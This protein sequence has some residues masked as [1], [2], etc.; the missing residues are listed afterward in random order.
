MVKFVRSVSPAQGFAGLHSGHGH[1]TTHPAM[2][3]WCP[4]CHNQK[5]LQLEYTTMYW[6]ALGR[7]RKKTKRKRLA[8]DV[9]SGD[10]LKKK[11]QR[12]SDN[13]NVAQ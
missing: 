1:G 11:K 13:G 3:R 5:D 4:T 6:G 10:N 12:N 7:G 2:L 8:A 9:S